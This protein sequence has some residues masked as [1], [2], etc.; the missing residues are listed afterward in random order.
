M[1]NGRFDAGESTK[2]HESLGQDGG[3]SANPPDPIDDPDDEALHWAGDDARG[4]AAPR[5]RGDTADESGPEADAGDAD[6]A[7]GPIETAARTRAETALLVATGVFA[8][9]F[10]AAV[11]GWILSVQLLAYAGLD[12]AGEIMWQFAE[13][14]SMVAAALWFAAVVTL[15]PEGIPRRGVKRFGWLVAGLVLLLP[16]PFL[17]G[18]LG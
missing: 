16:W 18:A 10:L 8:G 11:V 5:L 13:F 3:V 6:A 7:S 9:L 15:T 17:L 2:G 1:P 4:Q 12:L 14:L